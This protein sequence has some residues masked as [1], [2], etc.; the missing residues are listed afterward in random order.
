M[1]LVTSA[2]RLM[3]A[4][5][6][7]FVVDVSLA[8]H[9]VAGFFDPNTPVEIEGVVKNT[10]W[11]N[12]HTV[13]L[14]DVTGESGEITTWTIESGALG[15]LRSRGLAREFVA[16]GDHVKVMGDSSLRSR[17]EMFARN[18]LLSDG[19]EV[20]LTAGSKPHFTASGGGGMLEAEFDEELIAAARQNADGIFRVWSTNI[21]E[22]RSSGGRMLRGDYPVNAEAIEK[23]AQYDAGDEALLGC[24][25]WSMP[26]LMSN[27]LPMEFVRDGDT[28]AQRFEENDS[29]RVI[30]MNS[31]SS[32]AP[33]EF[34][35]FGYSTGRWDG[36]SLVV[37]TSR[38]TPER[39]DNVGTPFSEDM[40]LVERFT[41]NDDG[42]RLDYRLTVTD[43]NTFTESFE[44]G[45]Y[46]IWR[47]E[48]QVGAYD[49]EQDQKLP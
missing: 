15:V 6:L 43:P 31:A 23:R 26:R 19:K 41:P 42:S 4:T 7:I 16:I 1:R 9:S 37:E 18:M 20:M 44:V 48:M 34:S 3:V 38:V 13:F 49:C 30:H 29:V 39:L 8:H 24:T 32:G 11:R 25:S 35:I 45:R 5:C 40:H 28:I 36:T 33:D 21:D 12:P 2:S 27:P 47:P 17:P 10:R 22:R 46:W 14:I